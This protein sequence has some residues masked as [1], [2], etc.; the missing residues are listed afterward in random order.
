MIGGLDSV[1]VVQDPL[2]MT[3]RRRPTLPI[4]VALVL[5]MAVVSSTFAQG[6]LP[7]KF[8]GISNDQQRELAMLAEL[9]IL[10]VGDVRERTASDPVVDLFGPFGGQRATAEDEMGETVVV[11]ENERGLVVLS[12]FGRQQLTEMLKIATDLKPDL[13]AYYLARAKLIAKLRRTRDHEEKETPT[14]VRAFEK[15]VLE[16]GKAMGECEARVAMNQALAYIGFEAKIS[17]EQ[18]K[19]LRHLRQD[20][21]AYKLDS[22]AVKATRELLLQLE[23][24]YPLLLQ[25]TAAKMA[26]YL[27]G[28]GDQNAQRRPLRSA[29]LLGKTSSRMSA[30]CRRFLETL[31]PAQQD[32]LIALLKA[33]SPYTA[34]YVK[35]R[36]EFLYAIDGLKKLAT[37]PEKKYLAAGAAMGELEAKIALLQVKAFEQLRLSLGPS[38]QFFIEQNL[39]PELK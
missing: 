30:D 2:M 25:D 13:N 23:E 10:W 35:K 17:E 27:G 26:S 18:R 33:E 24:P 8:R 16:L 39:V 9:S 34:D 5:I 3:L 28:T 37:V 29:T 7:A 12:G 15:E 20:P 11:D 1:C 4:A 36:I 21:G 6:Q 19:Y 22:E 32:R 14:E 31:E 38:Q